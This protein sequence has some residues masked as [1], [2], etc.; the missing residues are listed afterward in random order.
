MTITNILLA[1]SVFFILLSFFSFYSKRNKKRA[2][3]RIIISSSLSSLKE[4]FDPDLNTDN[5]DLHKVRLEKFRRSQYKGLTF[6]LSS[7]NRIY[8][9]SEKGCKIYC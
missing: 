6:F 7:E 1:L 3:K 2:K 5:W 9:L 4:Q 8:Y